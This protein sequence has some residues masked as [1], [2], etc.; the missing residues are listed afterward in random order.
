MAD[1]SN[2]TRDTHGTSDMS[3]D[4]P[5]ANHPIDPTKVESANTD[6]LTVK[7]TQ[8]STYTH[9]ELTDRQK[10]AIAAIV[11]GESVFITGASGTGKTEMIDH[12]VKALRVMKDRVAVTSANLN[13][14]IHIGCKTIL[15]FS[16]LDRSDT[17]PAHISKKAKLK[18][19]QTIWKSIDVMI[20]DDINSMSIPE[21]QN[22]IS[23][24][25]LAREGEK[26]DLQWV[27]IGDFL[28]QGPPVKKSDDSKTDIRFVF[29]TSEFESHIHRCILLT[30]NFR[31]VNDPEFAEMLSDIRCGAV[32]RVKWASKLTSRVD[33]SF[34]SLPFT[35]LFSKNEAVCAENDTMY[36]KLPCV[37]FM[38]KSQKGYKIGNKICPIHIPKNRQNLEKE[39][40]QIVH[41]ISGSA[42]QREYTWRFLEQHVAVESTLF[43]KKGCFVILMVH[44]N[45]EFG[46]IKG[47]Q[48]I[49]LGFQEH[50]PHYPI[51]KFD[52]CICTIKSYMW[53]MKYENVDPSA[54]TV[55]YSQIPLRL[56]WAHSIHRLRGMTLTRADINM[57][58]M[59][60]YGQVYEVLS[61]IP[62]LTGI[63]F[64]EKTWSSIRTFSDSLKYYDTH[65]EEW[66]QA[67]ALWCKGGKKRVI[68]LDHAK[69]VMPEM[70]LELS[71][72]SAVNAELNVV[73][74]RR[75]TS[76]SGN[77]GNELNDGD[78]N[79]ELGM[80][81]ESD[82]ES[83]SEL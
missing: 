82:N 13:G 3:D 34:G 48:G 15:N 67:Y 4:N 83:V 54:T 8:S 17:T 30:E 27:F 33:V 60:E 51:V 78:G 35:K 36:K 9:I 38:F 26:N 5:Y 42:T 24:S 70:S 66:E 65:M 11:E 49:V 6:F 57:R 64:K 58:E 76:D 47:T 7:P 53:S 28:A 2:E 23:L 29:Q 63:N 20:I 56:G 45:T 50:A 14:A 31:H 22:I 12:I 62:T 41:S 25:H 39:W 1:I 16:G 52:K 32:N 81:H 43:L 80:N 73:A 75:K 71:S 79:G 19:V 10:Y 55:W 37:E 59:F 46:L 68:S 74:K 61:K 21:F 77:D 44:L 69:P 72:G 40:S 18:Y